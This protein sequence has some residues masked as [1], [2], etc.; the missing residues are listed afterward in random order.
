MFGMKSRN[1]SFGQMHNRGV[2]KIGELVAASAWKRLGLSL[3]IICFSSLP[4]Y[5]VDASVHGSFK[6]F[7]LGLY[8]SQYQEDLYGL[9]ENALRLNARVYPSD[10]LL[11]EAAYEIT[12]EVISSELLDSGAA[13]A[14]L[15]TVS[16]SQ[17]YRAVD[18][19]ERLYPLENK[20]IRNMGIYHNLDRFYGSAYLPF[21]DLYLGRQAIS[22]G[23]ARVVN[24]TDIIAPYSFAGLNTEEKR[25]V[26]AIRLRVPVGA[27]S[28]LDIGYVAGDEFDFK[29]SAAFARMRGYFAATD[30]SM[31]TMDFRENLLVGIDM[32]RSIGGAGSWLEV[33]Y[34]VPET[35]TSEGPNM[36]EQYV[37]GSLGL[38]YN[39]GP[40]LYGYA[41]YHYN[42]AGKTEPENYLDI[43][44][45]PQENIAYS[46][47]SIY[48]RARH[49]GAIGC[50]YQLTPLIPVSGLVLMNL[51]DG[52][53]NVSI[54]AEYNFTENV[55]ISG[56]CYAGVGPEP[57]IGTDGSFLAYN[58][59]FGTYADL[60][61]LAVKLYF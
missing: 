44:M 54:S 15:S 37:T 52:S 18:F 48:L 25:G 38:D 55:Y 10:T 53:A 5:A 27:M 42:S 20:D 26:D 2:F 32:T 7:F 57:D 11:F 24:P 14:F 58:S 17:E 47:G 50:T 8:N 19:D 30:V 45:N 59:E 29:K 4:I 60:Y 22:W 39:F 28:E 49:Y 23:S 35:F 9:S 3:I 56:G 21:G 6:T 34:V 40:K 43:D 61:Y 46:E 12:P 13:D 33:S 36:D 16:G 1:K 31:L 41:E 51:N